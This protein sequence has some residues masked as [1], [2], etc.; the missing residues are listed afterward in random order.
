MNK[1]IIGK[2]LGM[3]QIFNEQG[4]VVPVTVVE[5]GPCPVVQKKTVEKDG[6]EAIQV[7]FG[8]IND[9]NVIKPIAGHYKKAGVAAKRTLKEFKFD[10]CADYELGQEIKADIFAVGDKVD[11]SGVSKGK[12]FSGSIKRHNFHIGPKAHGS[13]YHRGTGSLGSNSSPSRVFKNK[14]MPG[15]YGNT[16]CT[17]QNLQIVQV[18]AERNYLLIK[19]AI[20]GARGNVVVIKQTCKG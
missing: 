1:A 3:S 9:K 13:G 20:P 7:A 11:V 16:N 6:Y 10:N 2:K 12:G 4:K 5:A 8:E 15:Q 14:K 19:G 18:D 17:V